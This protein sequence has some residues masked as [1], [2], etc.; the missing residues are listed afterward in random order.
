MLVAHVAWIVWTAQL[1]V[2]AVLL[3]NVL[4]AAGCIAVLLTISKHGQLSRLRGLWAV[5]GS[6]CMALLVL[7]IAGSVVFSIALT[8]LTAFMVV[9]QVLKAYRTDAKGVSSLTWLLSMASSLLWPAYY[10]LI[11]RPVLI[12]PNVAIF[13]SAALILA[14]IFYVRRTGSAQS[15]VSTVPV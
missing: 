3:A 12:L 10:V 11:G 2:I 9:P 14:R 1:G 4:S 7:V 13:L 6:A 5:V 8:A 15:T